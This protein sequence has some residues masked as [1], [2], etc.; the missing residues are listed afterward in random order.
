MILCDDVL[1]EVECVARALVGLAVSVGEVP[2][3]W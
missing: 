1:L 2:E 3:I